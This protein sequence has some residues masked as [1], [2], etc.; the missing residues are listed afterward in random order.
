MAF[1]AEYLGGP[2]AQGGS[3]GQGKLYYYDTADS[4]ATVSATGHFAEMGAG[5]NPATSRGMEKGDLVVVRYYD[6][7]TT[8]A[9]FYGSQILEVTAIDAD[10][11]V[12]VAASAAAAVVATADGLTTGLIPHG[13]EL[14]N[15]TSAS[16]D[17]IIT[18]PLP[19][20]GQVVYGQ[21]AA[22][23]CEIRVAAG[24]TINAQTGANEVA[25]GANSW[26]QAIGISTTEWV[27]KTCTK[28]GAWTAADTAN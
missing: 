27:V 11:D 3:K 13:A 22:T 2:V 7:L 17:N 28:A 26:F 12:T 9:N 20:P 16:V 5:A 23:G 24:G 4:P 18:L 14:V 19:S 25:L 1:N 8:K 21:I 10:G 6:V 15:A